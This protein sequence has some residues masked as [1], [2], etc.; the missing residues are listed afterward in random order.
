MKMWCS[1]CET[2]SMLVGCQIWGKISCDLLWYLQEEEALLRSRMELA[3]D[4]MELNSSQPITLHLR[5]K[6]TRPR[7][8]ILKLMPALSALKNN[9][10]YTITHGNQDG[11]FSLRLKRG[12][13]S[14]HFTHKVTKKG[15]FSVEIE[16]RPD[17]QEGSESKPLVTSYI[18]LDISVDWLIKWLD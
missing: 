7:S 3:R 1:D 4:L 2:F 9:I 10:H 6:Q 16:C 14:L 17:H 15:H 11:I 5:R 8:A 13:T 18:K 12:V